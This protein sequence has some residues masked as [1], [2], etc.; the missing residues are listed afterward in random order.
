MQSKH[1][2]PL[3]Y[4]FSTRVEFLKYILLLIFEPCL[5]E[6][7]DLLS[8]RFSV[9][10]PLLPSFNRPHTGKARGPTR[11]LP[12]ESLPAFS[13][14]TTHLLKSSHRSVL[15]SLRICIRSKGRSFCQ[16][17]LALSPDDSQ[18]LSRLLASLEEGSHQASVSGGTIP[19]WTCRAQSSHL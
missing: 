14:T 2:L 7:E 18:K 11:D 12:P 1:A 8:K 10:K 19:C 9:R 16:Q 15:G 17:L 6:P 4:H 13:D 5:L 3:C